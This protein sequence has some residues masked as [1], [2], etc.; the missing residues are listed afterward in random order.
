MGNVI[1]YAALA[2]WPLITIGL[3]RTK[4]IQAATLWTL[5]G[6]FMFLPVLTE[7][8]LPLI[9]PLGKDSI[10]VISALMGCWFVKRRRI[11]FFANRGLLKV[12][13]LLIFGVPFITTELNSDRILLAGKFLPELSHH[14]ALSSVLRQFLF[15][16]PFF[17]GRRFFRTYEHQLLMFKVLVAA[18][19]FYSLPMMFEVRMSP[20]LHTWIYGYFPHSFIQ[21]IRSG[22]F[23][24]VVFMGH[25][26]LVAFFT[27]IAVLSSVA[28]WKNNEKVRNF[29]SAKVSYYLLIV[30][31]FC[32]STASLL[33]AVFAFFMIKRVS[34]RIQLRTAVI[35]TLLALSYPSLSIMQL[36]PHEKVVELARSFKAD[37]AQSLTYRFDNE[38]ILLNHAR[39]KL[40]FGWGGWGRNRVYSEA[41][42]DDITVTDGRWVITFGQFGWFGFI[43][44]FGLIAFTVFRASAAA[45][46]V[47]SDTELTLLSAHALLVGLI[48]ID[49]LPNA[50]LSPWLWLLIGVLLGRVEDIFASKKLTAK[51]V[52]TI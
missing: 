27:A 38:V 43:A 45:K 7:V 12:L 9:P 33:Y 36:F 3:Y 47:K 29:P 16:A 50:T 23:R 21:Q 52:V 22:G 15:V 34:H 5:I 46:L 31:I 32:K 2:V 1:A 41:T 20:Q 18:C 24:P 40:Y 13:V 35:L 14:D 48:M 25:G 42:G 44:E 39:E 37:R 26:L 6:G 17:M 30:L 19:L 8:D 51:K 10:P 11:A 4:T 28:L 49:Q